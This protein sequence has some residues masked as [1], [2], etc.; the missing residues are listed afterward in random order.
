MLKVAHI[1]TK[2]EIGGAQ[3]WVKDQVS[4]LEGEF[5]HFIITNKAGWLTENATVKDQL[6][7]PEIEKGFSL[8]AFLKIVEFIKQNRIDVVVASSA[9]AGLYARLLKVM[10]KVRVVYVSHGWSCIYNGGRFSKLYIAIERVLS[11][12]SDKILCV[13]EKDKQ[14]AAKIIGIKEDKLIH[15][16]N[17]VF[18]R[19][20]KHKEVTSCFKV[21]FLGRLAHPKRPDLLID[22]ISQLPDVSLDV[23]GDGP[24]LSH[25]SRPGNVHFVG[26]VE[27]FDN[28]SE[29]DLF[30]LISD[31]E[32]MPMSALEAASTGLPLLL[33]DV[34]GCGELIT[35]NGLLVENSSKAIFDSILEIKAD[36]ASYKEQ[37]ERR[38]IEFDITNSYGLYKA[39]YIGAE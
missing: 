39:L 15:I 22:A 12:L 34:G 7:V 28:F 31:S 3:T 10:T 13:S 35:K 9:N 2:S 32:G 37:A 11:F 20:S 21:L 19:K 17:C 25:C 33:S 30:A 27:N 29:Y 24:L 26:A 6:F 16:R 4:L 8:K 14:D 23:V 38:S 36:Y 18:P 1:I 5:E